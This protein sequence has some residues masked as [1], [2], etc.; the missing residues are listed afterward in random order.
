MRTAVARCV[1]CG[2]TFLRAE[3]YA[4]PAIHPCVVSTHPSNRTPTPAA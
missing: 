4:H 2:V 3:H 1:R